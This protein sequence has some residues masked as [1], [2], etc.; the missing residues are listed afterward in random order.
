MFVGAGRG[1]SCFVDAVSI[2]ACCAF[3]ALAEL[4]A[5]AA[6]VAVAGSRTVV[7]VS[8]IP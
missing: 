3:V 5:F 2:A 4:P 1:A 7:E 6:V 8:E